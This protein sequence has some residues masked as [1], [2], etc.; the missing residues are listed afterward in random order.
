MNHEG[1]GQLDRQ[2]DQKDL[3]LIASRA[4]ARRARIG[5]LLATPFRDGSGGASGP[6]PAIRDRR[7]PSGGRRRRRKVNLRRQAGQDPAGCRPYKDRDEADAQH[8]ADGSPGGR[9]GRLAGPGGA[10]GCLETTV[11]HRTDDE[12]ARYHWR[13]ARGAVGPTRRI[14]AP[15]RG[16]AAGPARTNRDSTTRPAVVRRTCLPSVRVQSNFCAQPLGDD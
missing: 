13:S 9:R 15:G 6:G 10:R 8:V 14:T 3:L 16:T 4:G 7:S 11:L 1:Q 5:R 2:V 12:H